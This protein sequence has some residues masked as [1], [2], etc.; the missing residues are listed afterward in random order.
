MRYEYKA[1]NAEGGIIH[2]IVDAQS[3][4]DALNQLQKQG[5]KALALEEV[6]PKAT[7]K[8]RHKHIKESD[9]V[10]YMHQLATLL[11]SDVSLRESVQSLAESEGNP[12]VAEKFSRVLD[13]ITRGDSFLNAVVA[14]EMNL[15]RYFPPLIEAGEMA[16]N[17]AQAMRNGVDQWEYELEVSRELK[18]ALTYPAILI[19]TGVGAI[20]TIFIMVVPKFVNL[21]DKADANLP[22]LA[23]M[24]LGAGKLFN[25]YWYIFLVLLVITAATALSFFSNAHKRQQLY[26]FLGRIPIVGD[27]LLEVNIARWG[28]LLATLLDNRVPLIKSLDMAAKGVHLSR[29]KARLVHVTQLVQGGS[30]LAAAL[31]DTHAITT[32]GYNL[33]SAGERAGQLPKM[34]HSLARVYSESSKTKMKRVLSLVEPIAILF[35]GLVAGT[36]MMG[37]ILAITSVNDIAI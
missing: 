27:W 33:I 1:L 11:E 14:A 36:I 4:L 13:S 28:A 16:G 32:T 12:A 22:F 26:D 18:G 29:V 37:I 10:I 9:L 8:S 31:K 25:D 24:V 2:S 5:L 21:L 19:L 35:I 30:P 7:A 6:V 23:F 17:M 3:Q 34:L 20:V 15:P